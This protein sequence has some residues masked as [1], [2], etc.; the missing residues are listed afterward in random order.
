MR[1]MLDSAA[2]TNPTLATLIV[3]AADTGARW[4]ELCALRWRHVD[5]DART[6]PIKTAIG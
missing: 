2:G 3:L 5:F 4:G 1:T 6:L